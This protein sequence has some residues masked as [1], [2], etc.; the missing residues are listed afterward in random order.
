MN[1]IEAGVSAVVGDGSRPRAALK[2][3]DQQARDVRSD[4]LNGS[5]QSVAQVVDADEVAAAAA[6]IQKVVAAASGRQLAFEID[7]GTDAVFVEVKDQESGEVLKQ[8]PPQE[9]LELRQ[10]L[11]S[12]IGMIFD[13]RA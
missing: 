5:Q 10:R 6:Q 11:D 13:E 1:R 3:A 2:E 9:V 12:M 8:I 7:E 4:K